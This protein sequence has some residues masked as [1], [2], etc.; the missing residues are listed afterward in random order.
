MRLECSLF[1]FAEIVVGSVK[2][3]IS[4]SRGEKTESYPEMGGDFMKKLK[5]T[6]GW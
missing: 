2:R 4:L 1:N 5:R 3:D 6:V